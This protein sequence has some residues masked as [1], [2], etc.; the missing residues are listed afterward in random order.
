MLRASG[1]EVLTARGKSGLGFPAIVIPRHERLAE[2]ANQQ[3][4]LQL[5]VSAHCLFSINMPALDNEHCL[6]QV[7]EIGENN[8]PTSQHCEW[9][10]IG[11]LDEAEFSKEEF[12]AISSAMREMHS[13][14]NGSAIGP[15]GKPGWIE[16]LT[17]WVQQ[18]IDPLD[19]RL[20]GDIRQFNASPTF[21]LLRFETNGPAVWFKAVGVPNLRE[22]PITVALSRMLPAFVPT[23]IAAHPSLNGWL[24]TECAG[25]TP[26]EMDGAHAWKLAAGT[27]AELQILSI[28]MTAGLLEAGCRD[29][30]VARLIEQVDPFM[31]VMTKVMNQQEKP[32]PPALGRDELF[33]LGIHIKQAAF[34]WTLLNIPD[35]LG[36][37]DLNPGNIVIQGKRCV[38]LDWA[39]AFVGSPF[40]TFQ[41]LC[42]HH[43][44]TVQGDDDSGGGLAE[45]YAARWKA[46][47]SSEVIA[48]GQ[49]LA[50]LLAPFAY[51]VGTELWQGIDRDPSSRSAAFLRSLTRRMHSESRTLQERRQA[52]SQL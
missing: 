3:V 27:L 43:Q 4:Q 33:T 32:S 6:Y 10:S 5:G 2:S 39:E 37:L 16:G 34:E 48:E 19:L 18:E 49:A 47:I 24:T 1:S 44:R 36:H 40:L 35:T 12:S 38:F 20:S 13:Y 7:M 50:G 15:F 21:A 31:E 14:V 29:L 23:L 41:Y 51:A 28:G 42:A 30:R 8:Q 45:H 25:L 26:G 17:S 11:E 9:R 22:F 46:V 52:C